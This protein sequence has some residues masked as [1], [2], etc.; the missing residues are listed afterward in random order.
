MVQEDVFSSALTRL[1]PDDTRNHHSDSK[2]LVAYMSSRFGDIELTVADPEGED[3]RRLFA[4]CLWNAGD[5]FAEAMSGC[6]CDDKQASKGN[7]SGNERA[8]GAFN[9]DGETVLDLGAGDEFPL[10][11]IA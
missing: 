11:K 1:F 5:W 8:T 2:P 9:V 3:N 6:K 10:R 4:N 7:P